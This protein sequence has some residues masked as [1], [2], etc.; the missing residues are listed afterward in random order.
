MSLTE[1]QAA[2]PALQAEFAKVSEPN[3]EVRVEPVST[4][5]LFYSDGDAQHYTGKITVFNTDV[6]L[7]TSWYFTPAGPVDHFPERYDACF[8]AWIASVKAKVLP[9]SPPHQQ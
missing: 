7:A 5:D 6:G 4:L 1:F 2:L 8:R 9:S 3:R